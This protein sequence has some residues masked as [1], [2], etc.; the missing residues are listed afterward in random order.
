MDDYISREAVLKRFE[1]L[2]DQ[3]ESL[4]DKLYLDGVAAVIDT[5][6]AAD[7]V[8]VVRCKECKYADHESRAI[9][10]A[11]R[12]KLDNFSELLWC[13]NW[14]SMVKKDGFCNYGKK[15][16]EESK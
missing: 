8:P 3:T 16:V 6:P 7:V 5:L 12:L 14:K 13:N 2:K 9:S 10:V 11:T 15:E 4:R 1:Q